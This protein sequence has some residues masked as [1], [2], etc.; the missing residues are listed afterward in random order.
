[1]SNREVNCLKNYFNLKCLHVS[2]YWLECCLDWFKQQHSAT[3]TDDYM[4]TEVMR[5]WLQT[6]IRD[7]EIGSLPN[8]LTKHKKYIL[9]G[10]YAVQIM[11]IK[12][13]SKSSYSQLKTIRD[14]Y[15]LTRAVAENDDN[16]YFTSNGTGKRVLYLNMTDGL[17]VINGF[18]YE[19]VNSLQLNMKPG[20]KIMLKGP[21]QI[22]NGELLL[23]S[24]NV[25]VL[26]GEVEE[27]LV[28]NSVENVLARDLNM[29]ENPNAGKSIIGQPENIGPQ[30]IIFI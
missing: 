23:K 6:D 22:R 19:T 8:N 20:V 30:V 28:C 24:N 14:M 1:M 26:G 29:P 27:L 11:F 9:N 17:Q 3:Y 18:E 21:L 4:C 5:Q 15:K 13:I 16:D 12:D 2:D 25:Q 7:I 10:T